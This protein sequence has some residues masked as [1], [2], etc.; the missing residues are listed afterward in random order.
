MEFTKF[1]IIDQS[2]GTD[3]DEIQVYKGATLDISGTI[4]TSTP[5]SS[6]KYTASVQMRLVGSINFLGMVLDVSEPIDCPVSM[7]SNSGSSEW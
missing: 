6:G 5:I 1:R 3:L 4:T 2:T 7:A